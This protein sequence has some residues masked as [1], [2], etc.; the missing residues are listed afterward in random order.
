[1]TVNAVGILGQ[2]SLT[3]LTYTTVYRV[4]DAT[5]RANFNVIFC[6]TTP[7]VAKVRLAFC[8]TAFTP[9]ASEFRVY[10][11]EINP[12]DPPFVISGFLLAGMEYVTAWSNI[13][14]VTCAVEGFSGAK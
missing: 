2:V 5:T 14:A 3:A 11:Y 1:M 10:D 4:P 13:A 7:S 6:N 8:V 12:N 9:T